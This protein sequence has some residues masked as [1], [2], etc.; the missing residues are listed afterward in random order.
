[1]GTVTYQIDKWNLN[2]NETYFGTTEFRQAGLDPNL[3]TVFNPKVV[4]DFAISYDLFNNINLSANVNNIFDILPEWKYEALNAAGQAILADPAQVKVQTNL[5]TFNGRY[6][7]TTYDGVHFSQL[8]RFYN[9][10][11]TYRF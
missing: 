3:K 1:V 5:I 4:S 10:S 2:V 6:Q 9:A 7:I 11:L 8:G